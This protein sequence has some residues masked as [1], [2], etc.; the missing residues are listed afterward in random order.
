MVKGKL[1]PKV[2][3]DH[4]MIRRLNRFYSS[5]LPERYLGNICFSHPN[6][7]VHFCNP[8]ALL[9]GGIPCEHCENIAGR[10][11]KITCNVHHFCLIVFAYRLG[12]GGDNLADA[13]DINSKISWKKLK[14]KVL[15]AIKSPEPEPEPEVKVEAPAVVE[16]APVEVGKLRHVELPNRLTRLVTDLISLVK[17]SEVYKCTPSNIYNFVKTG[18]LAAVASPDGKV[19]VS[20]ADV[21]KLKK[22]RN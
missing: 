22:E 7:Q 20:L 15:S 3:L 11:C 1:L 2:S 17:A 10:A 5:Q 6:L 21:E 19:W 16:I 18:K 4:A 12:I 14:D 8:E 9:E 13:V